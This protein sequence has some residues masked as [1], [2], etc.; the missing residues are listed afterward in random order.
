MPENGS[1]TVGWKK[2]YPLIVSLS[3]TY[4]S[5]QNRNL[6]QLDTLVIFQEKLF[7]LDA[8]HNA[9]D[10]YIDDDK[11]KIISGTEIQDLLLQM[12]RSMTLLRKLLRMNIPIASYLIFTNSEFYLYND[13]PDLPAV[14]PTQMPRFLKKLNSQRSR[15]GVKEKKIA[16]QLL[17]LHKHDNPHMCVPEYD[18]DR[19]EKGVVCGACCSFMVYKG[20]NVY[21]P[22][23]E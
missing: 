22:H 23:V 1:W 11:W 5:K 21:V 17:A 9:G 10:F 8:K 2:T 14:F 20:R 4:C 16:E 15:I 13:S 6:F 12:K 19:L 7:I 3:T 18:Y